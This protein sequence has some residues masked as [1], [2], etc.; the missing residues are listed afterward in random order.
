MKSNI[1][2]KVVIIKKHEKGKKKLSVKRVK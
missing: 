2:I 1:I